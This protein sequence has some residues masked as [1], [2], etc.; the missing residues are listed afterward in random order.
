VPE[1]TAHNVILPDGQETAPGL[2]PI[3]DTDLCQAALSYL[4]SAFP[5]G[6]AGIWVADL[7]CLEGGYAVEFARARYNVLAVEAREDNMECCRE[8]QAAL[9]LPNLWFCQG[10]ARTALLSQGEFDAV[11]C[12]GLL[13]HL[14]EPAAFLKMLGGVT[15]RL[16]I[17]YTHVS[18]GGAEEH[19]GYRG[20]W[21]SEN[22]GRWSS[23]GN[24]QSFWLGKADVLAAM[25]A[26]GFEA[27][28]REAP[29]RNAF[30]YAPSPDLALFTG[31]KRNHAA[32]G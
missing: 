1:F 31:L 15:K 18:A 12:A 16:L 30:G 19:E 32:G 10:D 6:P 24:S 25:E 28:E 22:P 4:A 20:H 8:V 27:A 14:D 3:A 26:A 23:N 17:I 2:T 29:A 7:G 9:S 5:A 11:F 21:Y 13:Y